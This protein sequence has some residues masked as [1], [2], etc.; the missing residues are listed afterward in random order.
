VTDITLPSQNKPTIASTIALLRPE[1]QR[2]LPK[3]MDADR[4]ARLALTAV[5]KDP[6]LAECAP[7]SFAGALLT[8]AALGLEP[9]LNG[10][11]YLV[12]YKRE[13]T[14]IVGYQGYAK[15]FFQHPLARHL[16]A[17]AVHEHD[18]FD[19]AYGLDPY[20]VHKPARGDRG[21][22]TDYY[23]VAALST[24]AKLFVVLSA[25]EVKALRGGKVGTSGQIADPQHWMERKTVL[26]QLLKLL[27]KSTALQQA[28][29]AD[30]RPGIDLQAERIIEARNM[31]A[32]ERGVFSEGSDV[33]PAKERPAHVDADG[34]I[35]GD[36]QD[37]PAYGDGDEPAG[38]R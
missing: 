26:R 16:D 23:A 17:Q 18:H 24:G 19:Y 10:E 12:A 14:L 28:V 3:G 37:P 15:L 7:E 33:N 25:D 5:R 13:C 2:A 35:T 30:E 4:I 11:A 27:P 34:V 22:I 1:I 20:L 6:K 8:A 21:P 32:I 29:D 9:N 36:V 38:W 31:A